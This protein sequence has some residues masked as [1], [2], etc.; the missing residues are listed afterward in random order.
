MYYFLSFAYAQL[1]FFIVTLVL[2]H[3]FFVLSTI[4][5][6]ILKNLVPNNHEILLSQVLAYF[7]MLV[8]VFLFRLV[9]F[10]K[11]RLC[12][13]LL[14]RYYYKK[15]VLSTKKYN[16]FKKFLQKIKNDHFKPFF[17]FCK[18]SYILTTLFNI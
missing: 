2:Y 6:K 10:F 17:I 15:I 16:F 14:L 3:M 4:F 7:C 18:N 9:S 11:Y 8:F 5:H 12:F 13:I 1:N